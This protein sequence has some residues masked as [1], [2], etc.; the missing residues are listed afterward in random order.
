MCKNVF[1]ILFSFLMIAGFSSFKKERK[2]VIIDAGHGGADKGASVNG[3]S[4][5]DINLAIAKQIKELQ[6]N[7][8]IEILL[9]RD[10]D[11]FVSLSD[12]VDY[13]NKLK[14]KIVLSIHV[15]Y[16]PSNTEKSGVEI[17][18]QKSEDSKKMAQ[19]L[20]NQFKPTKV[21]EQNL[22]IL[23]KSSRPAILFETGFLSHT[24]DRTYLASKEGQEEISRKILNFINRD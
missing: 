9:T 23:R 3:I 6:K 15:N 8:D 20:S 16:H 19:E 4:E 21:A 14:P 1:L 10:K 13:I 12:R 17:Y 7:D 22:F 2:L 18:T 11:D 24:K 5:K